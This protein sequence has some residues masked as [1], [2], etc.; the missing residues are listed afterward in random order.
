MTLTY[1]GKKTLKWLCIAHK[2]LRA[3]ERIQYFFKHWKNLYATEFIPTKYSSTVKRRRNQDEGKT[4]IFSPV[5][6][7]SE[8]F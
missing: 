5:E 4:K 7:P 6:S 3:E 8:N 2:K 1:R